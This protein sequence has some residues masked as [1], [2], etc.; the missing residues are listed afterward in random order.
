VLELPEEALPQDCLRLAGSA[1]WP[2][3]GKLFAV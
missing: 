3:N 1:A 2:A